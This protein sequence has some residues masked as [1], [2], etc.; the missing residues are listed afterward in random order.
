MR[1]RAYSDTAARFLGAAGL[2]LVLGAGG[3]EALRFVYP[4]AAGAQEAATPTTIVTEEEPAADEPPVEATATPSAIPTAAAAT[5]TE[6]VVATSVPA[7]QP[8]ATSEIPP[9]TPQPT[10]GDVPL[11]LD[12]SASTQSVAPGESFTY[13]I[14]LMS[15]RS[16]AAEVRD[17]IDA[18]LEVVAATVDGGSCSLANPV[19]CTTNVTQGQPAVAAVTVRLRPEAAA[20]AQI[21]SQALAQDDQSFTASSGPVVVQVAAV[22]PA[23][24]ESAPREAMLQ[25]QAGTPSPIVSEEEG[26][27]VASATPS[28][29]PVTQA[30]T[31][32]IITSSE[33]SAAPP[34]QA[35]AGSP[36]PIISDE[37][38]PGA[39]PAATPMIVP[40]VAGT[41]Q[42][43]PTSAAYPAPQTPVSTD[44]PIIR[45]PARPAQAVVP[46][47]NTAATGPAAGA[48]FALIGF[49]L[50]LHGTRRVRWQGEELAARIGAYPRLRALARKVGLLQ[51]ALVETTAE[52]DQKVHDLADGLGK[53]KQ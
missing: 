21:I 22:A 4:G 2:L 41:V 44:A 29:T 14:E 53:P 46:L 32:T 11:R 48:G 49:A 38:A 16:G 17:F 8:A 25:Q 51:R 7:E 12:K 45:P 28:L 3:V 26:E 20:G 30:A 36:T 18:Q 19:V 52:M 15:V 35:P 13:R 27:P 50:I 23:A 39:Q 10:V 40:T 6:P 47:P 1:L 31:A 42:I 43:V 37:E 24:Q 33:E 34:A 9:A 5:A